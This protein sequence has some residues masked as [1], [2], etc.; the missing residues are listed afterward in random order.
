M[1]Q[2]SWMTL[3]LCL[4]IVLIGCADEDTSTEANT[5]ADA[6]GD[7][8]TS[9]SAPPSDP[10]VTLRTPRTGQGF[11]EPARNTTFLC[12][13]P[14]PPPLQILSLTRPDTPWIVGDDIIISDIP[15]VEGSVTWE[16]EFAI[17]LTDTGRRL[18]G[19]GLPNHPTGTFAVEEGTAAYAYYAPLPAEGYDNASQIPIAAYEIDLTLPRDPVLRATPKCIEEIF[20]GVVSQ[21][22]AAWHLDIAADNH[23]NL[24]DP[25]S[26]LPMDSC[27]GHPYAEQ[28]H[29][30]G[31]SWKCFPNQ[32]EAGAHS[33]LFGYAIDG[34]GVFGPRGEGGKLVTNE[35]LDECH[36]HTHE[37]E[38]DGEMKEMFH[39]HVNGEYPY[40]IGC[41]RGEPIALPEHLQ[42]IPGHSPNMPHP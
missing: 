12:L 24:L 11:G 39:Y 37:I 38:W 6:T 9:Q 29:Y 13:P 21:T 19:N 20:T 32:G 8:D 27:W 18:L 3:T 35:D 36:G 5:S 15:Y 23:N 17:T 1:R 31:Y 16:S 14:L 40:S 28:Y 30:H 25:V 7:T 10:P 22:G 42:H 2:I 4:S 41:F 34:F 33:P 26:A